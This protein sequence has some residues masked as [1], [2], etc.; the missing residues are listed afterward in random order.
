MKSYVGICFRLFGALLLPLHFANAQAPGSIAGDGVLII[1]TG[2]TYPFLTSGYGLLLPANTG[3]HYQSIGITTT[4]NSTGTYTYAAI[5]PSSATL[6]L[7]DSI[8]GTENIAASFDSPNSGSYELASPGFPGDY[9]L[10]NFVF[11]VSNALSS[12]TGKTVAC[13]VDDGAYPFATSGTFTLIVAG[14]GSTFTIVGDGVNTGSSSGT[15][16][17]SLAN[18][19]TGKMQINDSI[20]GTATVYLGMVDAVNGAYAIVQPSTGGFQVGTFAVVD[21]TPPTVSITNPPSAKTYTSAQTV[22]ISA[23]ALDNVGVTLVEFYDGS[24]LEASE[25]EPPFSFE[26]SFTSADNGPHVWTAQ[27]YDAAGNSAVSGPVTLTVSIDDTPPI[28]SISSPTNGATVTSSKATISGTAADP[29]SPS[30]GVNTVQVQVNGGAWQTASGKTSWSL[31]VTL[32]P[33]DNSIQARSIDAAGNYSTNAVIS[34]TYTPPTGAP[35]AP[36]NSFPANAERNEGVTPLLQASPFTSTNP[37]CL[38]DVQIASQW[39]V[40]NKPGTVVVADSGTNTVNLLSWIVPTNKLYYGSN[41]EWRVRYRDNHNGW[42]SYSAQTSF[43]TCGPVLDGTVKGTNLVF[44]WPTNSIGFSLQSTTN[45]A[46]TNWST[47]NPAAV[48][49]NGAY[50][51][52]NGIGIGVRFYRLKK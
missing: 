3:N 6:F 19:S 37:P 45:A 30:S 41:Y 8:D 43:S 2:G 25:S 5:G 33:C 49:A 46:L 12:L 42:S 18:K 10:G 38:F 51:V 26:W 32:S 27:A 1:V 24:T 13:T 50:T 31:G 7:N 4:G 21:T 48:I 29:G 44:R 39:Q 34:I 35:N 17:Y 23:K 36:T 28:I 20:A 22:T 16:S 15:Y 14:S 47:A 11:A 40:L 52:S 9:Q